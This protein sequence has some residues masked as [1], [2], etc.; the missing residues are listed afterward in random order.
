MQYAYIYLTKVL[1]GRMEN[2]FFYVPL[3]LVFC[4]NA[5]LGLL[6][7]F[8]ICEAFRLAKSPLCT[9]YIDSIFIMWPYGKDT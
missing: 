5:F 2:V 1:Y 6:V 8:T 9:C 7:L 3:F 4:S